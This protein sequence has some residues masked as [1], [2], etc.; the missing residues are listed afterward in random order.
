LSE[1]TFLERNVRESDV[2]QLEALAQAGQGW[3]ALTLGRAYL[4]GH[5]VPLDDE[6]GLAWFEQA[7]R[8]G[9][10]ERIFEMADGL[11][12]GGYYDERDRPLVKR[13][14]ATAGRHGSARANRLLGGMLVDDH[15]PA[16]DRERPAAGSASPR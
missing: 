9:L 8:L 2:P 12:R 5:G 4:N 10:A 1:Q 6:Q 3:A 16:T 13:L 14:L 7:A 11:M 15:Q